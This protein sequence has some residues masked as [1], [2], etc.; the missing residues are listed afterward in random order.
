MKWV[1]RNTKFFHA[2]ASQRRRRN[3]ISG[4]LDSNGVWQEDPGL[5]EGIIL[6]YFKSIF[7]S[8]NPSSFEVCASAITPKVTSE[9]NSSL[10]A[11]FRAAEVWNA[12]HQMHPTKSPGLDGMS[13]I[14]YQK[15]WDIV[16]VNVIDY[17]L[18]ILNTG[19]LS[20]GM[21]ET[22]ICLFPK[23]KA[24]RK[25]TEYRPISFVTSSTR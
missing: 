23:T 20:W 19:V 17:V 18:N 3:C 11:E 10:T 6:D 13:P 15:Y 14:F 24:P 8:D 12:F 2:T 22:Y 25:I 16:G 9:M 5:M 1:D 4:L 21:N 7:K